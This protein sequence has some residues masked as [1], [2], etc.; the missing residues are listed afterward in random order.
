MTDPRVDAYID[1]AQPFARPILRKVRTLVHQTCPSVHETMKWS[2]PHFDYKGMFCAMAAFKAHCSFSFWKHG[3]LAREGLVPADRDGMGSF[4]RF[5][6]LASLPSDAQ[7]RRVLLA[8]KALNDAGVTVSRPKPTPK[9]PL[10]VPTYVTAAVRKNKKAATAFKDLTPSHRREY[11]EWIAD[12]KG[13]D[14]RA[15]RIEKMLT[16]LSAGQSLNAK[17]Q[18]RKS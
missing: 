10:R 11:V 4:G 14:T 12:A 7:F 15:R 8:A 3:L 2:F 13:E 18:T 17:Y 5:T 9:P 6:D 1:Q 16:Q